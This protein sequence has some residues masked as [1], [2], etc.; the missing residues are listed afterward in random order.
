[1]PSLD[2]PQLTHLHLLLNHWPILGSFMGFGL[3]V[4]GYLWKSDDVKRV[5]LVAF[6]VIGL[7]SIPTALTGNAAALRM[8]ARPGVSAALVR[9]HFGAA[10]VALAFMFM[11]G[12]ASWY[13]LW[14]YRRESKLSAGVMNLVVILSIVVMGLMTVAGNTGGDIMHPE[15]R[16]GD[17]APSVIGQ[18]GA[19]ITEADS[20]F[21]LAKGLH[22]GISETTHFLGMALFWGVVIVVDLRMLGVLKGISFKA[23]HRLLP[24]G[25]FGYSLMVLTGFWFYFS[26]PQQYAENWG[27]QYKMLGLV[28]LGFN[29][30]YFTMFDEPWSLKAGD[31]ASGFAKFVAVSAIG[32]LLCVMVFGRLLPWLGSE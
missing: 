13:G 15:T 9:I 21:I 14:L 31:E 1:M 20:G 23:M 4:M 19:R 28:I 8:A 25:L 10:F 11:L 3:L 18:I 6:S 32:L 24:W 5:A 7:L 29:F 22:W 2:L 30:L 26:S 12:T 16:F 27:F 17:P